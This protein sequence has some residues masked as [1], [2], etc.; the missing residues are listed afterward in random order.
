M[1]LRHTADNLRVL[2]V[3][4]CKITDSAIEGIV[5][6]AP[7]IQ[8]LNL[9]KCSML[10]D[11]A[12]ECVAKLGD[13]LDVLIIAHVSNVTDKGLVKIARECINLRIVDVACRLFFYCLMRNF[14][15]CMAVCRNLT[16]MS[17]FELAGLQSLRRL[18]LI[19]VHK[20]TDIGVFSLAEHATN[21]ERLHLSYCD[22]LSLD[23]IHLLLQKLDRLQQL[24][25][26]GIPCLNRRQGVQRFSEPA[27]EVNIYYV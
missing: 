3:S 9:T 18:N 25:A 23:A 19:R 15:D 7:R 2:D 27:P 13:H 22:H 5:S 21:L 10:T 11:T 26:T 17:V 20:L 14:A 8:S 4:D 12:L 24:T 1:I 16:D 6:H